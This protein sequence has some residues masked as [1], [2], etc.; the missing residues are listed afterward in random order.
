M[1]SNNI[2]L[3]FFDVYKPPVLVYVFLRS[4]GMASWG[5][6]FGPGASQMVQEVCDNTGDAC[7]S[8][9]GSG[10]ALAPLW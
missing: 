5:T 7:Q 9:S 3:S 8:V 4:A 10:G 6:L 1:L 2:V